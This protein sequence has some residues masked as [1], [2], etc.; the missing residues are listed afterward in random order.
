VG[1][2]LVFKLGVL[3]TY[4]TRHGAG[5]LPTHDAAL[6]AIAEPHN[7]S[8]GWQ[9]MFRRGHPDAVL[10]RYACEAAQSL[11][12]LMISHLDYFHG[13]RSLKWCDAYRVPG[14][15]TISAEPS[16]AAYCIE[17][18]PKTAKDDWAARTRL[19]QLLHAAQ[20]QYADNPVTS[21]EEAI[22]HF[23][24]V[25]GVPVVYGAY[26]PRH[27]DVRQRRALPWPMA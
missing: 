6:D 24:A 20:P 11:D 9:G 4:L 3:R 25:S 21:A 10:L 8:A 16:Q 5:P 15:V 2:D 23:E 18:L 27:L 26:G 1:G 17:A 13:A 22:R 19:T 7:H 14:G 12:G